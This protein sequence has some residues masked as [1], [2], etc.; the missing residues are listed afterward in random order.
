[1]DIL[2]LNRKRK[3]IGKKC[4]N[5]YHIV[6]TWRHLQQSDF[7]QAHGTHNALR[8]KMSPAAAAAIIVEML[9]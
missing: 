3:K 4:M 7:G 9:S 2:N 8:F 5:L 1:M 6:F